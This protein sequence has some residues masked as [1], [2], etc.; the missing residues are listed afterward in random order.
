MEITLMIN[1][2]ENFIYSLNIIQIIGL[3]ITMFISILCFHTLIYNLICWIKSI[4]HFYKMGWFQLSFPDFKDQILTL[5]FEHYVVDIET[6]EIFYIDNK[7]FKELKNENLIDW[8]SEIRN[9]SIE[10][11]D[12][13]LKKLTNIVFVK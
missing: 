2:I 3:S 11:N 6:G 13:I 1:I 9:Y 5:K 7:I 10:L 8:D 12:E 4:Y